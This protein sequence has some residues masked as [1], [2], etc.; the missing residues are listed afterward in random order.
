[1]IKAIIFDKDGTLHDT[2]KVFEAAWLLAARELGVPDIETTLRD[3]T[4]MT[5]PAIADYWAEKYPTIPFKEYLP[6]RQY[7]FNRMVAE[8]IPVKAGA[9]ELLA[10]LRARG[11]RIGLATSTGY[12][13][14]MV[15]LRR[16]DMLQYFDEGAIITGDMVEQGKPAPDI[17]LL[18]AARLGVEP[19]DCLG[20][21]DS[22]N[23]V[24]A[25]HAAGM[26]AVMIP[27]IVC[28]AEDA[29]ALAWRMLGNLAELADVLANEE[30]GGAAYH[31]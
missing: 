16:T 30:N 29:R 3:C 8:E 1:M 23:G 4:G 10:C 6:R 21:E 22:N 15:H 11:Y 25:I 28:P 2:E 12:A 26:R 14:A 24:R 20:V 9:C 13:D 7:H 27:D 18:A 31:F 5:I 17:Y 19:A